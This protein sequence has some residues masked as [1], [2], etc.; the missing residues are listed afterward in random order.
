MIFQ[1]A[2]CS[3]PNFVDY[4]AQGA[5]FTCYRRSLTI[6]FHYSQALILTKLLAEL[7]ARLI[8]DFIEAFV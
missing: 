2:P 1:M 6:P 5:I 7:T 3:L 8:V 4:T